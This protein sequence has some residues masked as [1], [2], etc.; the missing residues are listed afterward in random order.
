ML[1]TKLVAVKSFTATR[2]TAHQLVSSIFGFSRAARSIAVCHATIFDK[3]LIVDACDDDNNVFIPFGTH[4][5]PGEDYQRPSKVNQDA[6]FF[7][8]YSILDV[9]GNG[10]QHRI[11]C[12]GVLDGHGK[13]G[14]HLSTYFAKNLPDLIQSQLISPKPMLELEERIQNLANFDIDDYK[15]NHDQN[16]FHQALINS[17][18]QVH[19]DA[20]S[21]STIKSGRSGATC[22]ACLL[23]PVEGDI[24]DGS[25]CYELH[26]ASVGDSRA[27]AIKTTKST[28]SDS[29]NPSTKGFELDIF[30]LANE[31]TVTNNNEE[32]LRIDS[33][34]DG[35][36]RGNNVFYG[37]VGIAMTRALGDS[38]MLRAGVIPT[39]L[40]QTFRIQCNN[41]N[42]GLN[43]DI[44]KNNILCSTV[45]PSIVL[46]TDGIWDVLSNDEVANIIQQQ[47]QS[48]PTVLDAQKKAA[49]EIAE[50]AK[51]RWYGDLPINDEV[52]MDD[53]TVMV[54]TLETSEEG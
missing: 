23:V 41:G 20:M 43:D 54:V 47:V 18:L 46:A 32:R 22:I 5:I 51:Q 13:D 6:S 26:V 8:R 31:M 21:D 33:C 2:S 38:V 40:V 25:V 34:D 12:F 16:I 42:A 7:Q 9:D 52:K 44:A 53:I 17:F 14:H 29:S 3:R 48:S 28:T 45:A 11:C 50:V 27:I 35:T 1:H 4:T 24:G 37:P 36:I 30:V 39:P 10:D 15:K 19:W 49:K